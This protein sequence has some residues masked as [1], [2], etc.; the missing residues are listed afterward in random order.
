[1][2]GLNELNPCQGVSKNIFSLRS[3]EFPLF[4]CLFK[5]IHTKYGSI[6]FLNRIQTFKSLDHRFDILLSRNSQV[7]F[8][9][10]YAFISE[11]CSLLTIIREFF[12]LVYGHWILLI[13][14]HTDENF[15]LGYHEHIRRRSPGPTSISTSSPDSPPILLFLCLSHRFLRPISDFP[16]PTSDSA[17]IPLLAHFSTHPRFSSPNVRRVRILH[18][19]LRGIIPSSQMFPPQPRML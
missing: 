11:W 7:G 17:Y 6:E 14:Y 18:I 3:Q 2:Y 15:N 19:A 4:Q 9:N 1:M 16:V 5:H 13:V 10:I 8:P 12:F